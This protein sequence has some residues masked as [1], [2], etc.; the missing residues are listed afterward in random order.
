MTVTIKFPDG[1]EFSGEPEE[2]LKLLKKMS[3]LIP[4]LGVP[5]RKSKTELSV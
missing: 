4:G 2:V 5:S 1:T 3:E